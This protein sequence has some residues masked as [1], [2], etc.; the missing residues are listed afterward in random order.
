MG[1]TFFIF[2]FKEE[3]ERGDSGFY[4]PYRYVFKD[5]N[6]NIYAAFVQTWGDSVSTPSLL[7]EYARNLC[8]NNYFET[9]NEAAE[10]TAPSELPFK[11]PQ[12][13]GTL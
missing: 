7:L 8:P 4:L 2:Q 5:I 9:K 1:A 12:F 11:R 13:S 6:F 10:I 3:V